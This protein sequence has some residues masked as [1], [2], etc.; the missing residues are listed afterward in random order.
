M[1]WG[2]LRCFVEVLHRKVG[3]LPDRDAFREAFGCKRVDRW[4][5][6]G[7]AVSGVH[8]DEHLRGASQE[9]GGGSE[10]VVHRARHSVRVDDDAVFFLW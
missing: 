5:E 8:L 7:R 4:L 3:D 10:L 1:Y 2:S 6:V 9:V